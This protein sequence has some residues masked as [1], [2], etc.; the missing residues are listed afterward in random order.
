MTNASN[1]MTCDEPVLL[2]AAGLEKSLGHGAGRMH[3]LRGLDLQ[4]RAGEFL[5]VMGPS[6][7]GKSTLLHV[8]GLIT[9][10]EAGT[11]AIA[12]QT[13]GRG[14]RERT[15]LRRD[16]IGFVFQ[17][18]NLLST[19]SAKGNI[20]ISMRVRGLSPGR[21][22]TELLASMGIGELAGRKPHEMSIGQ[23]QRVAIARALAHRPALL[24]ADEPTGSLDSVKTAELLEIL[25][26]ANHREGQT[27]V[28]ITHSPEVARR[29]DRVV[30]MRDG[31]IAPA[32][33]A[34]EAAS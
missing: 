34:R 28:M 25:R 9:P 15:K 2:E 33:G 31:V 32:D 4:V 23:Q 19:L 13:V 20:D 16:R 3:V 6:G 21:R 12:G 11:L 17:R 27:I 29:A 24:L 7:C 30:C 26:D 5:A 8:L 14:D 18:L 1:D 10:A 22:A